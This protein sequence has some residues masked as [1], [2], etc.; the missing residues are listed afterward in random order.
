MAL[1]LSLSAHCDS[2]NQLL[3]KTTCLWSRRRRVYSREVMRV[4]ETTRAGGWREDETKG[5]DVKKKKKE[6][7]RE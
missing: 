6:Y 1:L 3:T 5:V 2:Q 4:R 7:R